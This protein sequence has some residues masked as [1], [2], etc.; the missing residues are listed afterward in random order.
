MAEPTPPSAGL[1]TSVSSPVAPCCPGREPRGTARSWPSPF[2]DPHSVCPV[3]IQRHWRLPEL[4]DQPAHPRKDLLPPSALHRQP[5]SSQ[6]PSPLRAFIISLPKKTSAPTAPTRPGPSAPEAL[7]V[8]EHSRKP[9]SLGSQGSG[10]PE[11]TSFPG[12][13]LL[14]L[15][16]VW[17]PLHQQTPGLSPCQP[18]GTAPQAPAEPMWARRQ[19]CPPK[20]LQSGS[21]T[22]RATRSCWCWVPCLSGF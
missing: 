19:R 17:R 3:G 1:S 18:P 4:R 20:G 10:H 2:W 22:R 9:L 6:S 5:S 7:P 8:L 15:L 13:D 16:R 14:T 21:L 11:S 12:L